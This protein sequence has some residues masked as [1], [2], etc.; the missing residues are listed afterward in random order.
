LRDHGEFFPS[1]VASIE[2][3]IVEDLS[4]A[5]VVFS[6]VHQAKGLGFHNVLLL[7]DFLGAT[8]DEDSD[9]S[10]DLELTQ[11]ERNILYVAA[12][13][14]A[15]GVLSLGPVTSSRCRIHGFVTGSDIEDDDGS[16]SQDDDA[17]A[18]LQNPQPSQWA[19]EEAPIEEI[20]HTEPAAFIPPAEAK[21]LVQESWAQ[22]V[23]QRALSAPNMPPEDAASAATRSVSEIESSDAISVPSVA[24]SAP[25]AID[26][27][28][29]FLPDTRVLLERGDECV[30]RLRPGTKLR[31]AQAERPAVL[32]VLRVLK[33]RDRDSVVITFS[34][35][36]GT[37]TGSLAVTSSHVVASRRPGGPIFQR[38]VASELRLGQLLRTN[39]ADDVTII[40]LKHQVVHMPVVEIELEDAHSSFFAI[41]LG[42]GQ[43]FIEVYGCL[44]PVSGHVSIWS[45]IRCDNFRE[46]FLESAETQACRDSLAREGLSMDLG[47]FDL[48]PGKLVVSASIGTQVVE[49]LKLRGKVLNSGQVVVS[50]EFEPVVLELVKNHAQRANPVKTQEVLDLSKTLPR[51]TPRDR[52]ASVHDLGVKRLRTERTFIDIGEP[53][54]RSVVTR[55][56]TDAH[57]G[58]AQNPRSKAP[59]LT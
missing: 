55:S 5:D 39:T 12:S 13:R 19:G 8:P 17:T 18:F 53:R 46:L 43:A 30:M 42:E 41:A 11:E 56:T 1:M 29:C 50:R 49:A 32:R 2:S 47:Q 23:Q 7:D 35:K 3:K 26:M 59:R 28:G 31:A 58:V 10:K 22:F 44:A 4:I 34:S 54:P 52:D 6:T 21:E 24:H 16:D 15:S 38:T 48:G 20:V 36:S 45:F 27:T 9:D 14:V 57:L 33:E 25:A 51:K 37:V 40:D